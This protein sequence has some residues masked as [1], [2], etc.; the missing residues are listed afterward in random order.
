MTATC[1]PTWDVVPPTLTG[2]LDD[3]ARTLAGFVAAGEDVLT[4][5]PAKVE[6]DS[7]QQRLAEDV[8]T[9]CRAARRAFLALHVESVYD[10]LTDDRASY[11]RLPALVAAAAERFPGLVPS[12]DQMTAE[13]QHVQADKEGREIDQGIFCAAVLR[14]ATAGRHLIDTMLMPTSRA[15]R[16]RDD[17]QRTG[18]AELDAVLV[19]RRG[20]AAEL[21]FRNADC[22]NAED[23]R[24]IAD[25]ET[26]VDLALLDDQVRVGVL[27][28]GEVGHPRYPGKRVFSAG[29]NLRDLCDGAIPFLEFLMS[30]ELGYINKMYRGLLVDR[31]AAAW[32]DRTVAKP[33]VGAVDSFAIGGGMQLLLVL[34]RVIAETDAYFSLPAAEEGI[35]PGAGNLR[36]ARLTGARLARQVVLA[37]RKISA[38]SAEGRLICDEVVAPS[39]MRDAIDRAVRELGAPAVAANRRL[40]TVAEEPLDDFRE[41]LAEFAGSQVVRAYSDDVL[42][43]IGRRWRRPGPSR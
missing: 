3:D 22:L 28:G 25:Q 29:I 41:Y 2:G 18:V 30:R 4:T 12:A 31:S 17:F 7:T 37:G 15:L 26:A 39:D 36:L 13:R 27:R 32:S 40:L 14:S 1:P 21:T 11:P 35:V 24:L 5:L 19:E 8:F 10:R 38:A 9:A 43:K 6:R 33:W 16:L 42:T 20:H 23:V 34:D